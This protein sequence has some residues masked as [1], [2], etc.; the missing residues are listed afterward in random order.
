MTYSRAKPSPRYSELVSFYQQMHAEGTQSS[1]QPVAAKD[2]FTGMSLLP[3]VGM[4]KSLIDR[5]GA[6][7][8]LDYGA[9]KASFYTAPLFP[10]ADGGGKVDIRTYWGVDE[11][12]LYDPGYAPLS[13]LPLGETFDA[14][15]CT[16]VMEHIPEEDM[17]WVIDELYGFANKMVYACIAT[18]PAGK[19]FPNGENVHVTLK[20]AQWWA[21]KF[22]SRRAALGITTDYFL[23]VFNCN[24]DPKP[25]AITSSRP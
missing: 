6:R 11:I 24:N 18:Y 5:F 3:H 17:D 19:T 8:V 1:G 14:V 15:I 16:D 21:Q 20:N 23:V 2:T 13:K 9:G 25:I 10:S 22:E 4:I 7:S 12:R